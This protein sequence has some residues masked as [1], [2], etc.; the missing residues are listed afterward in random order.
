[1]KVLFQGWPSLDLQDRRTGLTALMKAAFNGKEQVVQML[2]DKGADI[3]MKDKEG[4][5]ALMLAAFRGHTEVVR[6]LL[7]RGANMNL[8]DKSGK[9]AL[10]Y[11]RPK[12]IRAL[13]T[14]SAAS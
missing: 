12:N 8:S 11:A 6:T 2:A 5:T 13:L 14:A 3:D 4:H 1:M 10:E 9:T 7:T